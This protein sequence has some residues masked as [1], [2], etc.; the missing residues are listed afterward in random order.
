MTKK[1]K[2]SIAFL[3][4]FAMFMSLLLYFPAGTLGFDLGVRASAAGTVNR[5]QPSSGNGTE[6]SPYILKTEEHLYWFTDHV[7]NGNKSA[8]AKLGANITV[9]S[10]VLND[11]GTL[12][13]GD[14]VEWTPI[15]N[16]E[17]TFDGNNYSISGI[18]INR[19]E[20]NAH[21]I[22]LFQN[23]SSSGVVQNV[24]LRDSYICA[25][26]STTTN[27]GI[28]AA[29][30]EIGGICG[31]NGGT[32]SGC[33]NYATVIGVTVKFDDPNWGNPSTGGICGVLGENATVDSCENYGY[34]DCYAEFGGI[35]GMMGWSSA[36]VKNCTNYGPLNASRDSYGGICGFARAGTIDNCT[37]EADLS[38]YRNIGGIVG[39]GCHVFI[40]NCVNNGNVEATNS[41]AGGIGGDITYSN[42]EIKNCVNNGNVRS[43]GDCVGGITGYSQM[44]NTTIWLCENNGE[45]SGSRYVGGIS[46][47][48]NGYNGNAGTIKGSINHGNISGTKTVGGIVGLNEDAPG[49]II[50]CF[51]DGTV[52][53]DSGHGGICGSNNYA[54][55]YCVYNSEKYIGNTTASNNPNEENNLGL[56]AEQIKAGVAAYMLASGC[57]EAHW[58][59]DLSDPNET[60]PYLA[61]DDSYRVYYGGTKSYHNHTSATCADC[62]L[63]S[64]IPPKDENG[65]YQISDKGHLRWFSEFGLEKKGVLINNIT[66]NEGSDSYIWTPIG[67]E[68]H[69][70]TGEI[71]GKGF[72]VS[73]LTIDNSSADNIGLFGVIGEGGVVKNLGVI[74]SSFNGGNNVGGIAGKNNG[75]I[76]GCFSYNTAITATG[77]KG[78]VCAVNS[79]TVKNSFYLSSNVSGTS[80][81]TLA[82]SDDQFKNGYAAYNLNA[83]KSVPA[84]GQTLPNT[85]GSLPV[86]AAADGSNKVYYGA[87][88]NTY[89][90]H[91]AD[92]VH[93]DF[94]NMDIPVEPP[95]NGSFYQISEAKHLFWFAQQV[96]T[97]NTGI[98][99]QIVK[100]I[101]INRNVLNEDGTL[102]TA[103]AST[104]SWWT[105]IGTAE[106]PY[107][108]LFYGYGH[109]ISGLYFNDDTVEYGGLFGVVN[110]KVDGVGIVDSYF[111][112]GEYVGA[113]AGQNNNV[114]SVCF[115]TA[116]V[117][118]ASGT[119][120]GLCADN[121]NN[122]YRS[123]Y[124]DRGYA[125]AADSNSAFSADDFKSGKVTYEMC[126]NTGNPLWGQL[127]E[128]ENANSLPVAR[129][130]ENA[131]Y[132]AKDKYHNHSGENCD[133][134]EK[135][136]PIKPTQD[137]RGYYQITNPSNLLWFANL[138]N[139]SPLGS[140][141]NAILMNDIV[142]NIGV[143]DE[144]GNPKSGTFIEWTPIGEERCGF[145][146]TF[147]G[148]GYTISG[149]Y[150]NGTESNVGLFGYVGYG[151]KIT[152]L[153]LADSYVN[154]SENV[155]AICGKNSGTISECYVKSNV[156]ATKYAGGICGYN[157]GTIENCFHEGF[158][159]STESGGIVGKNDTGTLKNCINIG[160]V[161]GSS[162]D[163]IYG[164]YS[165][166]STIQDCYFNKDFT[167][168]N[169]NTT[170]KLTTLELTGDDFLPGSDPAWTKNPNDTTNHILYYPRLKNIRVDD[171]AIAYTPSFVIRS[172]DT[173]T[174][175]YGDN[176][177]YT[178]DEAIEINGK[179]IS[180]SKE[181]NME[182]YR[183]K[184]AL[185]PLDIEIKSNGRVIYEDCTLRPELS[186]TGSK[187]IIVMGEEDIGYIDISGTEKL[188][189]VITGD[190]DT[191]ESSFKM[192][193]TGTAI[194]WFTGAT[195]SQSVTIEKAIPTVE[196]PEASA[197]S[198]GQPLSASELTLN[199]WSW[200]YPD[201]IPT[202]VNSG[203]QVIT[204]EPVDYLN[205]DYSGV[206]NYDPAT[207]LITRTIPVTVNSVTPA[208]VV[209]PTPSAVLPGKTV[210]V[211]A[212][213]TNPN[214]N[215]MTDLPAVSFS[216][217]IGSG[218]ETPITGDSFEIPEDAA[219][220]TII[221]VIANT[222]ETANY[223]AGSNSAKVTVT[224]CKHET[225]VLKYDENSHWYHCDNCGADLDI[226]EHKGGS[227]TCTD[228]AVCTACEQEYGSLD[229]NNHVKVSKDWSSDATGHWHECEDCHAKLD[230][231]AHESSGSATEDT[232]EL[233]TI[234]CYVITRA[235]GRVATPVISPNGGTFTGSQTVAIS[236]DTE[237]VAI[238]YTTNGD[239]PTANSTKY[240]GSF[241]ITSSTTVKAIAFKLGVDNSETAEATFTK[242][243]TG[244]G[245]SGGGG[246]GSSRPTSP[247]STNPS[248]G[249]STKSWSDVAADLGK[250]VIGSEITIELNGNTTVPAP[251]IKVIDERDLKVTFVVDSVKSWKT[252]GAEITDPAAA[253]LSIITINRLKTDT[254]RGIMGIQFTIDNTNIPTDLQIAFKTEHAGKFANLYKNVDGKLT[255]VTCAKLGADGKVILSGV[256]EKGDYLVM[257][258][259]F[260]DIPGDMN[261]DGVMDQKD[262]AALLK[263]IVGLEP[264][265]NPLMADFNGDGAMDQKDAS[266]ILKRIVGIA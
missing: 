130:E 203:Y 115:S 14:Y 200:V 141:D 94:C 169:P 191:G 24:T 19:S 11:D 39:Y 181:I 32:I 59:Q 122:L 225:K 143:L 95:K 13:S 224:D 210:S 112:G 148:N 172:T 196:E 116:L 120:G 198:Y 100:D 261:N 209:K 101:T 85:N 111:N 170:E 237:N 262:A 166:G 248:I 44:D 214:N 207:H 28:N 150:I 77:A 121:N 124:L 180:V 55:K 83:D 53:A 163:N 222:P 35:V 70:F 66:V 43:G 110:G 249:G 1:L 10:N 74:G 113:I 186:S 190:V 42:G 258:C 174:P 88:T 3:T 4:V 212:A 202:V 29:Y 64:L 56:T 50:G 45:V 205:Y 26:G 146:G 52:T 71:D 25:S 193:Y 12:K 253:D 27:G 40:T 104:F 151:G 160:D 37:N 165:S 63:I 65:V 243:S 149:L 254:L 182:V 246:G 251:V 138:T 129:T 69:P 46:G 102:N 117:E 103:E 250:L 78:G 257:L 240:T 31:E 109:Y 61:A 73:G 229:T 38:G 7:N 8:C 147:D 245:S 125:N 201:V 57:P 144:N 76:S 218:A 33:K 17:G 260:S 89:H 20:G 220:G 241:T 153:R 255:F 60:V 164:Y 226:E 99:A 92:L 97:G 114:I 187:L 41:R 216:Y 123:Y 119:M 137:E 244:G 68:L 183:N 162:R 232:A 23:I 236:C 62:G 82:I 18:Y 177:H 195:G 16:Y 107:T 96:N 134:C 204:S 86:P 192:T 106:K 211:S 215:S 128:G 239:T 91:A 227:A 49:T 132:F 221:T 30:H 127:L 188:P 171:S 105:P 79:S 90:N 135:I 231:A 252:D 199:G 219:I 208:I 256:S 234:C 58:S 155:G 72:T 173:G 87:P 5:T 194:P 93:C 126:L 230:K 142:M 152:K 15:E 36:T 156:A 206:T 34:I 158:V 139:H 228:K 223:F 159:N 118:S 51:S 266:A 81:S 22:G 217:K 133:L 213:V 2:K 54:V 264:G 265:K 259:E 176:L 84:W 67:S 184:L 145:F 185:L 189:V 154:G 167:T 161:Q 9:N 157:S 175:A 233:C 21:V 48:I 98:N 80:D 197:L 140:N 179:V 47:Y 238:Y 235:S 75:T 108:G 6:G 242:T 247:T 168:Y 136:L 178:L 131:V 263:D